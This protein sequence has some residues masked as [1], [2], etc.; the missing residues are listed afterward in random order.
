ML[1]SYNE[2]FMGVFFFFFP[3]LLH[4]G[5]QVLGEMEG[6]LNVYLE[7]VRPVRD[8]DGAEDEN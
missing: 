4:L 5:H 8:E 7:T 2:E 6:Q 3:V 1:K